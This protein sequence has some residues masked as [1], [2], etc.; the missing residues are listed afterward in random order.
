M[1]EVDLRRLAAGYDHRTGDVWHEVRAGIAADAAGLGAGDVVVDIGGGR[2]RHAAVF[3][4]RGAFAV[5]LDLEPAMALAAAQ[6]GVAAV[7]ADGH[8]LPLRDAIA[9]LAY[10]HLSLHHGSA[11]HLIAEAARVVAPGG[12][13]WVWTL[14]HDHAATSFLTRWFPS[15]AAIDAA[16]FPPVADL[17]AAMKGAGLVPGEPHHRVEHVT[18]TAGSWEAAVR[19]GFVST[20][21]LV[22][23]AEIDEGLER[24]RR[25]HPDPGA[26]I[27]YELPYLGVAATR[28]SLRS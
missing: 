16:R 20:L 18:R 14:S 7:V 2:G 6:V 4:E 10:F 11:P 8:A 21:H 28:P 3:A 24:F 5:V 23:P 27:E 25:A 19:A 15:V 22:D 17:V 9:R 13:V 12:T 26:A 1:A